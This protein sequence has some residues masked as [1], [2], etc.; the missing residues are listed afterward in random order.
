MCVQVVHTFV[1]CGLEGIQGKEGELWRDRI[2]VAGGSLQ[3]L[4]GEVSR[5]VSCFSSTRAQAA[6]GESKG[7]Q[8]GGGRHQAGRRKGC[9]VPAEITAQCHSMSRAHVA[10]CLCA[11]QARRVLQACRERG[12]VM[13][14]V[15]LDPMF[16]SAKR[17]SA[18]PK[19]RMQWLRAY[20]DAIHHSDATQA[21]DGQQAQQAFPQQG[22]QPHLQAPMPASI[23][24]E[25]KELV[26]MAREVACKVVLK[27]ADDGP[28]V[29]K[30]SSQVSSSKIV[31]YDVYTGVLLEGGA[32]PT[33]HA[34]QAFA[35]LASFASFLHPIDHPPP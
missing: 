20:L 32:S 10:P 26:E 35:S 31:R 28:V 1:R 8:R 25:V 12:L 15:Y 33:G 30:P 4:N 11:E 27:R 2:V 34:H 16:P 21:Q 23:E 14:V 18:L 17:K 6:K 29:G 19:R 7:A 13:D 3:T 22:H 24:E 5:L 9:L